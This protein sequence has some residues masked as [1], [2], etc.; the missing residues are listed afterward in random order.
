M[1]NIKRED[2]LKNILL[3]PVAGAFV[4][5]GHNLNNIRRGV[6]STQGTFL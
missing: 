4:T 1:P 3:C 6:E 2:F 5:L